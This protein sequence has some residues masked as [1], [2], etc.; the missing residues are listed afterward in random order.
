MSDWSK[1]T[2]TSNYSTEFIQQLDARLKDLAYGLDPVNVLS[3]VGVPSG[4]VRI[5]WGGADITLQSYSGSTWTTI[6]KT[7]NMNAAT[8]TVLAAARN[9]VLSGD[10]AATLSSFNG[11]ANVTATVTLTSVNAVTTTVGSST[12][13]PVLAFDTKG[14]VI[15]VSSVAASNDITSG[16]NIA[17]LI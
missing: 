2:T 10:A 11:S 6:P 13:V 17:S 5:N 9:L 4:A 8:A 12:T 15:S 16:G 14:R 7:I 3:Y 1:P